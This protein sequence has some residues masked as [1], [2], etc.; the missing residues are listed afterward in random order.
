MENTSSSEEEENEKRRVEVGPSCE[1]PD[2]SEIDQRERRLFLALDRQGRGCIY[3]RD[4]LRSFDAVGISPQDPRLEGCT[5]Q[6]D[7]YRDDEPISYPAFC[8]L[9][10][11][12]ILL[13]ERVLQGRLCIPDFEMFSERIAA[14]FE[15]TTGNR[16]GEVASY[17]PQLARVDPEQFAVSICTV[18]GQCF[19]VG[20]SN[21]D[22]C[23]QSCCKPI[24][25]CLALEE[26][27][28]E[29]V[30]AHIGREPSG[31]GFNE[32]ALNVDG[33]PHNPMINAGAIMSTSLIKIGSSPA[34]R[35]D[36]ILSG[37]SALAGGKR[38]RYN[39]AVYLSERENADR[40][41]ALGYYMRE[42]G[43]F[44]DG[45]DLLQ[46]LELYFQSCSI[47][48]NSPEMA[49]IAA[50]LANGGVCP[51]DGQRVLASRSVRNCLSLMSSCGMYD[52]SGE[53]AFSIGLPAKSGVGGAL[54]IVVP[55]V[56]GICVW[57]PRLDSLGNSVR[58]IDFCQ[59]LVADFNFHNY[60]NITGLTDKQDPRLSRIESRTSKVDALIW[61]ATKGDCGA[62]ELLGI[63]GTDLSGADYDGRTALHLAA[64]EGRY[65]VAKYLL[66]QGV[67]VDPVDHRDGTPLDDAMLNHH[68]PIVELLI[69]H[70]AEQKEA[71]DAFTWLGTPPPANHEANEV[72]QLNWAAREGDIDAITR[73]VARGINLHGADY[74]MR[75]PLHL[76]AVAGHAD[77][78][79]YL[80]RRGVEA[81]RRDRWGC[82][83]LD[84]AKRH[85]SDS[86]VELLT[87]ARAPQ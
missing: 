79:D 1:V 74:D 21:V 81:G 71:Q 26:H 33:K 48:L 46:T 85:G 27:G 24:N 39:N 84:D 64:A 16:G 43:G 58:G 66:D 40:N 56:M 32:L 54:M 76:A 8:Q 31:R 35:F 34:D 86:V 41:F 12:S 62:V 63:M 68:Q 23:V 38:P 17:I 19:D 80:L 52:F 50:T 37:W 25:Y 61:A 14:I 49:A 5:T 10:R 28:E 4:L 73:L 18:D 42:H 30:H 82:T 44:P 67:N 29:K 70:G 53:F 45:A 13:V 11:P 60:D 47:E 22:F 6:L 3:K 15:E 77:V 51:L 87:S 57:S 36:H 7:G 59:R 75:T 9:I 65:E 69:A 2:D 78:V 72:V 20:D 55:N 83:P